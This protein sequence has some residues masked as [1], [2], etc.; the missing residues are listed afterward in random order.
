MKRPSIIRKPKIDNKTNG[1]LKLVH[2]KNQPKGKDGEEE[3]NCQRKKRI[4]VSTY[5]KTGAKENERVI[6][7]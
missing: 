5:T 4:E 6:R 7:A 2:K 1:G 3:I